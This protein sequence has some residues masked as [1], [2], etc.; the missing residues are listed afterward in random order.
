MIRKIF[1][2]LCIGF[3]LWGINYSV[4]AQ[5]KVSI[6]DTTITI[7]DTVL[8]PIEIG[9][10][11]LEDSVYSYQFRIS[12]N[13]QMIQV[14][15]VDATKTLSVQWMS[16]PLI[17]IA[18]NGIV[19]VGHFGVNELVGAGVL[20]Y[21]KIKGIGG[22][23]DSSDI[24]FENFYL[25]AGSPQ[26]ETENGLVT[27]NE[28]L[29]S[30]SF[31]TNL[32]EPVQ[33]SV[34]GSVK[35]LP[36]DTTWFA[37]TTHL[38]AADSLQLYASDTR[39]VFQS[40]SDSG[41]ISHFVAPTADIVFSC[42]FSVEY[43]L[44]IKTEV[45]SAF[46]QGW[47]EAG[48]TVSL[49]IDSIVVLGDTTRFQFT[50][51]EGI[52]DGSYSGNLRNPQ[53]VINGPIVQNAI[54]E[55]QY[56]VLLQSPFGNPTGQGWHPVGDTILI[57][58]DSVVTMVPGTRHRFLSWEGI[59]EGS[60]S[61][62]GLR[63]QVFVGSPIVQTAIWEKQHYL[64]VRSMPDSV[65]TF[66]IS[67]WYKALDTLPPVFADSVVLHEKFIYRF[68][69]WELDNNVVHENP[70]TIT[71]DTTHVLTGVYAIDS[72]LVS[73]VSSPTPNLPIYI[74]NQLSVTPY[75]QFWHYQSAYQ[76]AVD[77]VVIEP[78]SLT[79]YLYNSWSN[80]GDRIQHLLAD[81]SLELQVN[82]SQQ[83]YL[84]IGT[85][86][87]GIFEFESIGWYDQDSITITLTAPD[88]VAQGADTMR[89][90]SW[91]LDGATVFG[92]PI[93]VVMDQPHFIIANYDLLF[94]INGFIRDRRGLAADSVE[95]ILSGARSDTVRHLVDG[96]YQFSSL[97]KGAYKVTPQAEW[98]RFEPV[99]RVFPSLNDA[100]SVQNFTAIDI[101]PPSVNLKTPNGGEIFRPLS[102]DTIAWAAWDNFGVDSIFIDFSDDN[103]QSWLQ[104]ATLA[105]MVESVY[106]WSVPDVE[107][108]YC[109]VR[110]RAVDLDGNSAYDVS[111][112]S[113]A[114]KKFSGLVQDDLKVNPKAFQLNQNYP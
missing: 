28:K 49:S 7:G 3:L 102:V 86:P 72:V 27:L 48:S 58:V 23:R 99:S 20:V 108:E 10:L 113:F 17:N 25:N 57:E 89:F 95:I 50:G 1:G 104:V 65:A 97:E 11:V 39:F 81:T 85:S 79:R 71:M 43:L 9:P 91:T 42:I 67:G 78:D 36:F 33:I 62:T 101:I 32:L 77:S 93:N 80:G 18:E 6:P 37:G 26:V 21:L 52:G 4:Q 34:D 84:N 82:F 5:V 15:G 16:A 106:L 111:D 8:I 64:T 30:V 105:D 88:K 109:L 94:Y 92:N 31:Q 13:N 100:C 90:V 40:W 44:E 75:H 22:H 73:I 96:F 46:G 114:I 76:I 55:K 61:G 14:L 51:W 29:I 69:W 41:N 63:A 98:A 53:I 107:S 47:H 60:Y 2:A 74:D 45:G 19:D 70:V 83:F 54:W 24:A 68:Q 35:S 103:G 38:I 66:S 87:Q 12:F 112:S 59:G 110:I 56:Y